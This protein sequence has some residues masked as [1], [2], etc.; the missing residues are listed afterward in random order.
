MGGQRHAA[1]VAQ[2][3]PGAQPVLRHPC[4]G[5]PAEAVGRGAV[6]LPDG[7]D[8]P[9]GK[10]FPQTGARRLEKGLLG[11]KICGGAGKAVGVPTRTLP[12]LLR[13]MLLI[14]VV[15][16]ADLVVPSTAVQSLGR[17][18]GSSTPARTASS[19]SWLTKAI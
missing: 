11:G 9:Q 5:L 15:M 17:M 14:M 16:R 3:E 8:L 7:F 10:R 6:F 2:G 13:R 18:S 12:S 4:G 1:F 19:I